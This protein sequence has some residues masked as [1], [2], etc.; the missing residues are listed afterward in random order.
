MI[1]SLIHEARPDDGRGDIEEEDAGAGIIEIHDAAYFAL[2]H[3]DILGFD[4]LMRD[5]GWQPLWESIGWRFLPDEGQDIVGLRELALYEL[6]ARPFD[7]RGYI[8]RVPSRP[9]G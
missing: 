8:A 4:I 3:D 6:V 7:E 9:G 5:P 1:E 2:F